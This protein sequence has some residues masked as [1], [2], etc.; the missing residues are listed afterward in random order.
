ML[1]FLC[2]V[3]VT[4]GL[5]LL[6]PSDSFAQRRGPSIRGGSSP[7]S[8][9]GYS[10]SSRSRGSSVTGHRSSSSIGGSVSGRSRYSSQIRRTPNS[11]SSIRSLQQPSYRPSYPHASSHNH[12]HYGSSSSR[13]RSGLSSL[14]IYIGGS[15]LGARYG[16]YG[17][18]R[19]GYSNFG[20]YGVS[21]YQPYGYYNTYPIAQPTY[22]SLNV[23]LPLPTRVSPTVV[24]QSVRSPI[25]S[26]PGIPAPL[27]VQS[28]GFNQPSQQMA[29]GSLP[30]NTLPQRSIV[31]NG[32]PNIGHPNKAV[33]FNPA[34]SGGPVNYVLNGRQYSIR[35]GEAQPIDLDRTWTLQFDRGMNNQTARYT[36]NEGIHKFGVGRLGWEVVQAQ[37]TNNVTTEKPLPSP[38]PPVPVQSLPVN[39]PPIQ[40]QPDAG[41][42]TVPGADGAGPMFE[43]PIAPIPDTTVP[44]L[45]AP[46]V[47]AF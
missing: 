46:G 44:T 4:S 22:G 16:S 45:E 10:G 18:S 15:S 21:S 13:N 30:R 40:S 23:V 47:D 37:T 12:Q 7:G 6:T 25:L 17:S 11:T 19:Y 42:Q 34:E 35:P 31:T 43:A 24:P 32:A 38:A 5:M 39:S 3:I 14:G 33:L 29:S 27:P 2:A 41:L 9:P 20:N 28:N 8:L 1:R 26:S 36:L